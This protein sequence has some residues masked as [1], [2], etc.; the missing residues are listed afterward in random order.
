[1]YAKTITL[2]IKSLFDHMDYLAKS[3]IPEFRML[4]CLKEAVDLHEW[5]NKWVILAD[6]CVLN[7]AE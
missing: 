7:N 1:M 2:D 5:V 3:K 6:L 4:E